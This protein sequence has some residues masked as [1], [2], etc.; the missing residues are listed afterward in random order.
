MVLD[1]VNYPEDLRKLTNEEK[2]ILAK[3]IRDKII[4]TVSNT[5]TPSARIGITT[6]ITVYPFANPSIDTTAIVKPIKFEPTSPI[7]VLAGVKLNGKN[8]A[9]DPANAVIS[10]IDIC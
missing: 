5:G 6:A 2:T 3:E 7:N 1:K 8:P 9:K 4:N 10:K